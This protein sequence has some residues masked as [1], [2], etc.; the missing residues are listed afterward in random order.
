MKKILLFSM[1]FTLA[2]A[3]GQ[4][5]QSVNFLQEGEVSKLIIEVDKTITAERFHVKDDKQIILD[6]KNVKV[7]PKLLRGIDTSEFDGATVYVSGY[8]RPG[9]PGDIRF[10]V[11]LR[12]NVRSILDVKGN[13]LILNIENR[14]GVFSKAR[15]Q[16]SKNEIKTA[17][18]ISS[19][20]SIIDGVN[21][22]IPKSN[23]IEDILENL[24]LSG[25]KKYVGKKISI[26]VNEIPVKDLLKMISETS[27]F[28]IILDNGVTAVPPMTLSLTNIPWDQAL[29]TILS[30][31]RLV[32]TKNSNILSVKTI[33]QTT[34]EREAQVAAEAL[35]LGLE[36][37]VTKVFAIS[38]ADI[39]GLLTIIK[40]YQTKDRGAIQQDARTNSL[41]VKDTVDAIERIQKIIELLDTQ[42]PQILIESKIVEAN[43]NYS[44]NIG[45]TNGLSFGYDA[46]QPSSNLPANAGPG[47][48]FSSTGSTGSGATAVPGF[49]SLQI[50]NLRRLTNLNISLELME[51]EGKGRIVTS[52]KVITQNKK[53]AVISSTESVN[54]ITQ[55][56]NATGVAA[57]QITSVSAV[58]NL[59]VT[60]QVTNE[61]SIN[62]QVSLSKGGFTPVQGQPPTT[63]QRT[64]DTN[65]LVDNGSTI[66]VGG[67]YTTTQTESHSGIPF[68]KDL[69][70]IGW[71][72]RTPYNPS[73]TRSELLVFL[74]PRIVNQEEAGLVDRSS[75]AAE[76]KF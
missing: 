52:P 65:V 10:A 19:D 58:L 44:K 21:L 4:R 57:S 76:N 61:G 71:L 67:L 20:G 43:E 35:K 63:T 29:D 33:E 2:N 22:N 73:N 1:L 45:L 64:I 69:P 36:P 39:A 9:A 66:V 74:T 38:Y 54:F 37:L 3:W 7:D 5:I 47:F 55:V 70:I 11:Q 48:N 17:D 25:P 30:L 34:K 42:T 68:L 59:S 23:S 46:F 40:D 14:F 27:G 28:N 56:P 18:S 72:F 8:P 53:A 41:I 62:L 75:L 15:L 13:K 60:P 51:S 49:A 32:A 26:N 12:D 50:T 16:D 31:A 24:V 6:L